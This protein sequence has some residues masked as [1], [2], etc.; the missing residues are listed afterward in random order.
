MQNKNI[1]VG[2]FSMLVV[3]IFGIGYSL[4]MMCIIMNR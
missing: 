4:Q 1:I 3:V 2:L